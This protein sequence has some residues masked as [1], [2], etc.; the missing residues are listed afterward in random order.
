MS[1]PQNLLV[2]VAD[3]EHA[4]FLRPAA[5]NA[6]HCESAFD[7]TTAHK[8]SS[9]LGADHPGAAMH[10]GS[11]AHHALSPRH[12]PKEMEKAKF[13]RFI[14]RQINAAATG[15]GFD[16]LILVAPPPI[17]AAVY[18][19]LDT[20]SKAFTVNTLAKDLTK[21]PDGELWPHVK[22]WVPNVHRFVNTPPATR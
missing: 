7:S 18:A 9:D 15:E 8:Q 22:T 3:G 20:Q 2:V 1:K 13:A 17:L 11:T 5:D 21:V 19:D 10:T 4:R 12:D 16:R 6:L 14:A